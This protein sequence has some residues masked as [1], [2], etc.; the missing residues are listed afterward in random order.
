[1]LAGST[2]WPRPAQLPRHD[3]HVAV[4][5]PFRNRKQ[6]RLDLVDFLFIVTPL[7]RQLRS[8]ALD[9]AYQLIA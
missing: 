2:G 8:L 5:L 7:G 3:V 9:L 6:L 4:V 1:M